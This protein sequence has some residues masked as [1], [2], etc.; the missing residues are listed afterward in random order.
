MTDLLADPSLDGML[1]QQWADYFLRALL[2]QL[3]AAERDALA[4]LCIFETSLDQEAFDYAEIKPEWVRRWLDLSLVQRAGGGM[5]DIPAADAARVGA[6]AGERKTQAGPAGGVHGASRG[7]RVLAGR[8]TKDERRS[9]HE[10]AAAY[11]GRPFVEMAR[12]MRWPN[13]AK[14]GRRSKSRRLPAAPRRRGADG[15][16]HRRPGPGP[17]RD[18]PQPGVAATTSSPPGEYE[19]AGEIVTAVCDILA[20][21]GERDRAK[22]LLRGSIETLEGVNKAVA[23]GNLATLLKDEGKLAEALATYEEVYRT[24]EAAGRQAADGGG[25]GRRWLVSIRTWASTTRPS[26]SKMR[27]LAHAA[28]IGDEEGQ[29]ISLHQLSMLY[30]LKED[31]AAALARSQEAEKLNRKLGIEAL[32]AATLHEQGLIYNRHGPRRGDRRRGRDPPR[33]GRRTLPGEPG[34]QPAHRGRGRRGRLAGRAGQA[35]AWMPGRCGRRLR[36]SPKRWRSHQRLGNPAKV[37]IGLEF[38]GSVHERQGQYAAAL[39]KY[40]QAL[41]LF[42]QVRF[43]AGCRPSWSSTLRGCGGRW[44]TDRATDKRMNES[45]AAAGAHP[46]I[47]SY[48]LRGS[49]SWTT[50]EK[51]SSR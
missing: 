8:M 44:A 27:S 23:Q 7:A 32:V 39:E 3:T 17:R 6:A 49:G 24:F 19:A 33:G 30:R 36:R 10:W 12:Q 45:F 18:G 21:W 31:Y 5:P 11:Y 28:R 47:R 15:G 42:A 1:A 38:L 16:P 13:P 41:E 20:R 25:A 2:A 4:R 37:G 48:P 34:D 35:A 22:A 14:A 43:A 46:F 51:R 29:A 50:R 9:A 26:R 40:Q